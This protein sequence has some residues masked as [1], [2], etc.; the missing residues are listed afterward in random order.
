[1]G[2]QVEAT[3]NDQ[4][5]FATW[6]AL[7]DSSGKD[8]IEKCEQFLGIIWQPDRGGNI[9]TKEWAFSRQM[10]VAWGKNHAAKIA[11]ARKGGQTPVAGDHCAFCPAAFKCPAKTGDA[12]RALQFD[13]KDL[14]ILS[15]N[16]D[17]IEGL[18]AWCKDVEKVAYN[19]LEVGQ[20]VKGWKL[21]AS[22]ASRKW[23]DEAKAI[24][25]LRRHLGGIKAITTTKM[26]GI[27]AI[28][29]LM[30]KQDMPLHI[31]DELTVK[32]SSGTTLAPESDKRPAVLSSEAFAAALASVK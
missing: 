5:L 20:E 21:V 12:L 26:L 29:K 16:M 2:F 10:V 13:P 6:A 25:A 27:G 22:R 28:E 24:K 31:L 14:E 18:K 3:N 11:L 7:H 8:L 15:T 23:A 32:E 30:K 9:Q 17:M 19:A 1:M 4:I